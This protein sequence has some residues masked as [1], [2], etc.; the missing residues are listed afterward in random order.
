MILQGDSL[1]TF[2][3]KLTELNDGNKITE[4]TTYG[5]YQR[6]N[7]E[8]FIKSDIVMSIEQKTPV[9]FRDMSATVAYVEEEFFDWVHASLVIKDTQ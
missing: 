5:W 8:L 9:Y 6:T 7:M 4:S 3:Q 1:A 2:R